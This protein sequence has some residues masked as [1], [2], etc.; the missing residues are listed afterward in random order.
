MKQRCSETRSGHSLCVRRAQRPTTPTDN[1]PRTSPRPT[2]RDLRDLRTEASQPD[3]LTL[4]GLRA[5]PGPARP[6]PAMVDWI[7]LDT[8]R[9]SANFRSSM[10]LYCRANDDRRSSSS[11]RAINN[12]RQRLDEKNKAK[13]SIGGQSGWKIF[14]W[15][16][17]VTDQS[18]QPDR[19]LNVIAL[20]HLYSLLA[21]L[22]ND[23]RRARD[24]W[25][26]L[27][28]HACITW[29]QLFCN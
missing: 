28:M 20:W 13:R 22:H 23:W 27:D 10:S 8:A 18:D 1:S 5:R 25:W 7:G 19:P 3:P 29:S 16:H 12:L 21:Y 4:A 15:W 9:Q 24:H 6:G 14:Y 11:S 2:G 26:S 17:S